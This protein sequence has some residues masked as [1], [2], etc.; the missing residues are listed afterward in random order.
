[1]SKISDLNKAYKQA[2]SDEVS[3][4]CFEW[5]RQNWLLTILMGP[6]EAY[7]YKK[8]IRKQVRTAIIN[9]YSVFRELHNL[10]QADMEQVHRSW[11]M[12]IAKQGYSLGRRP[13]DIQRVYRY[14]CR[15]H[16]VVA[17]RQ[18]KKKVTGIE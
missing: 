16:Q 9:V 12:A 7:E 8:M 13:Q 6:D 14:W 5:N 11:S 15:I 3:D 2:I 18:D 17:A 4:L 10:S 1:M